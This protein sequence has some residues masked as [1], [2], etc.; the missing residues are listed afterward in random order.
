MQHLCVRV[1]INR[2]K[3]GSGASGAAVREPLGVSANVGLTDSALARTVV[4]RLM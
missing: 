2:P 4:L 1:G 3:S